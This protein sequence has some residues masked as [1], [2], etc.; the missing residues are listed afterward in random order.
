[1]NIKETLRKLGEKSAVKTI[2]P[3]CFPR[4]IFQPKPPAKIQE[5]ID[6]DK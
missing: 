4:V 2:E 1:M 3:R 6:K 5:L